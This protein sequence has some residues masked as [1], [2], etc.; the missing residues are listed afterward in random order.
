MFQ[1]LAPPKFPYFLFDVTFHLHFK[2]DCLNQGLVGYNLSILD[3]LQLLAV[4]PSLPTISLLTI[5]ILESI[6]RGY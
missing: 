4:V 6:G 5:S 2:Y 1:V 3:Y